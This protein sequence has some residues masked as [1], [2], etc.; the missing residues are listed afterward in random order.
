MV[1]NLCPR[2]AFVSKRVY[3]EEILPILVEKTMITYTYVAM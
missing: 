3:V 1:Y 2:V